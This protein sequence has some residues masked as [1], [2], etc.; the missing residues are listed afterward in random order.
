M[1]LSFDRK[2]NQ[3]IYTSRKVKDDNE[4]LNLIDNF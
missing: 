4:V 2:Q 1:N 3:V